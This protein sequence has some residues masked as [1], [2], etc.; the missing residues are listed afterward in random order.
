[1]FYQD[2]IY[3]SYTF[4]SIAY[5]HNASLLYLNSS[6]IKQHNRT[7]T[8]M[9]YFIN[10]FLIGVSVLTSLCTICILTIEHSLHLKKT[11]VS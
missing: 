4:R 6:I 9:L 2:Y 11:N 7:I 8:M 5:L 10:Y 3:M 1:M